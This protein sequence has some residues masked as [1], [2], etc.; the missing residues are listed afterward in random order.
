MAQP[1]SAE[2]W[3]GEGGQCHQTG[4]VRPTAT[5]I[6]AVLARGASGAAGAHGSL[7]DKKGVW[8]GA[9]GFKA[10]HC[11]PLPAVLGVVGRSCSSC[12]YGGTGLAG[13]TRGTL[14]TLRALWFSGGGKKKGEKWVRKRES[15]V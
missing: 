9:V 5:Y 2:P 15:C 8:G 12:T 11:C 4:G 3:G 7:G 6:I 13:F 10:P 1:H 14:E